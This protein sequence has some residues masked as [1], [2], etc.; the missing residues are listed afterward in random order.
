[1]GR[2]ITGIVVVLAV[3]LVVGYEGY[4][5]YYNQRAGFDTMPELPEGAFPLSYKSGFR[6][7]IVGLDDVR[8]ERKYHGYQA[9][10]VPKWYQKSWSICRALTDEEMRQ[11]K[12]SSIDLGPGGRWEAVC[13]IDAG[14]D[15]FVRGWI[16]SV[17]DV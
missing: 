9:N 8:P 14:G 12:N 5:R 13:E 1:M 2:W 3:L 4:I 10:N 11:S 15:V 6:A 7:I 16:A 17:P